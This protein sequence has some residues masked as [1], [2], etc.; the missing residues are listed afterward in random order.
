MEA[1]NTMVGTLET[2]RKEGYTEDFTVSD[3]KLE[4][5]KKGVALYPDD[6]QVDDFFRFEGE[7][8]PSDQSIVYAISSEKYDLKG[9]LVNAFGTYADRMTNALARKFS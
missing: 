4:A 9:T 8:N 2:L 3:D 6:F 1:M 7:S 5:R